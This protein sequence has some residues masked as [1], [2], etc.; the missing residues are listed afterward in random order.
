M[1]IQQ[2]TEPKKDGQ[3]LPIIKILLW[4]EGAEKQRQYITL[5]IHFDTMEAARL[6]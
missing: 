3:K 1:P 2:K 5:K 6:A 4:E